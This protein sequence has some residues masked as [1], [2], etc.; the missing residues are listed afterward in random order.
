MEFHRG[1]SL[2]I[3]PQWLDRNRGATDAPSGGLRGAAPGAVASGA[4]GCG[5]AAGRRGT[6][7]NRIGKAPVIPARSAAASASLQYH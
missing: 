3:Q 5:S 1:V 6:A 7:A 2:N 4:R